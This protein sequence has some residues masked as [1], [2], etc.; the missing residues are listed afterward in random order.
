[1]WPCSLE[2]VKSVDRAWDLNYKNRRLFVYE[3]G[4]GTYCDSEFYDD[5]IQS[6]FSHVTHTKIG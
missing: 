5:W 2:S 1:V 3:E 6:M 4:R